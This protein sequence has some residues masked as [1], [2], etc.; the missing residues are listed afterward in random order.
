MVFKR[1]TFEPHTIWYIDETGCSTVTN[2]PKVIAVKGMKQVGQVTSAERGNLVIVVGFMNASGDTI[3]SAFVFPRAHYK[4]FMLKDSPK[5][6]LGFANPSGWITKEGF[7]FAITHCIKYTS[8]SKEKPC[9]I[10]ID[11]HKTHMTLETV[12][13][14][15]ENIIIIL[16]FP[17]HCSH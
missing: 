17:P 2:P 14:V 5:G 6:A 10:L 11:N 13:L 16:T 8:P 1:F 9:L 4:D 15:R 7:L 12:M 3:P